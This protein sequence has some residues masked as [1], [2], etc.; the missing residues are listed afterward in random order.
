MELVKDSSWVVWLSLDMQIGGL[1]LRFITIKCIF[2]YQN[3]R[4]EVI[5]SGRFSRMKYI[6]WCIVRSVY[7]RRVLKLHFAMNDNSLASKVQDLQGCL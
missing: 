6:C 3:N 4:F 7:E 5:G 1:G 2:V